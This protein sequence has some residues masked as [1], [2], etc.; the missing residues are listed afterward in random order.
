MMDLACSFFLLVATLAAAIA[1]SVRVVTRGRATSE[2]VEREGRSLLL[3]KGAMEMFHWILEP[4]AVACD[5]LGVT[6]NGVTFGALALAVAAGVAIAIGH[7]GVAAALAALSASGDGLDGTIARRT[8][9]ASGAGDVLD[10]AVDRY[11]ELVFLGGFALALRENAPLLLLSLLAILASFMVSYSTAKAQALQL[12]VPRGSMRRTERAVYLIL[13]TALAPLAAWADP[14]WALVP[15][16]AALLLVAVVGNVS[17][18]RR[19]V[20]V[21]EGARARGAR[22]RRRPVTAGAEVPPRFAE[23]PPSIGGTA[24]RVGRSAP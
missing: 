21:A 13:G 10:S 3:G 19:L 18:V 8:E 14:K 12:S 9:T 17:A 11:S 7:P 24:A 15:I 16:V 5:R 2:R 20:A 22:R 6:A 1:Y 23:R 4:L